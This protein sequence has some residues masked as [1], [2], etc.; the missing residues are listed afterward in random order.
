M[1]TGRPPPRQ[2][3]QGRMKDITGCQPIAM[4]RLVFEK[5][6]SM[7]EFEKVSDEV[8]KENTHDTFCECAIEWLR[9]DKVA[10][11]TFPSANRYNSKIRKL[12]QEHPEDVKI[13]FENLDGS[14]VATVPVKY[15][16]ISAPKVVSEE[17]KAAVAD[18]FRKMRE[19]KKNSLPE[20]D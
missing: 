16:K 13:R 14:I 5:G 7:N 6:D 8:S 12:A 20:N 19:D 11:V 1:E 2:V 4:S 3:W 18:R 9:G 17:Q 15:I 10:T